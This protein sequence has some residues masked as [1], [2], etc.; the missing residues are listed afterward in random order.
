MDSYNYLSIYKFMTDESKGYI[1]KPEFQ[2]H[3][4]MKKI[5]VIWLARILSVP[6]LA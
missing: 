4:L 2:G 1:F 3:R 6:L 5:V